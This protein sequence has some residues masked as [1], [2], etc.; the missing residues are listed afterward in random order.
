M[1]WK[2]YQELAERTSAKLSS[3]LLDNLHYIMGIVTESAELL[4]PFKKSLAYNKPL[5]WVNVQ[6]E[7]G[8]LVWY[9]A[10]FCRINNLD[11]ESILENN[12]KKLRARYPEKFDSEHAIYRDLNKEREVLEELGK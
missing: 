11:L 4:D 10:N 7:I 5:D 2:T 6:E 9:L 3:D 12:I 1:N 8:D